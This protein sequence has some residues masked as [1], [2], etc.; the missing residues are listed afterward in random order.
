MDDK[1]L[2]GHTWVAFG[3]AGAIGSIHAL[4]DGYTFK[5]LDDADYRGTYPTLD[6]AKSALQATMPS[7]SERPEYREH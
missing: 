1:T 2:T 3:P 7:R 6:A 5:L 4:D